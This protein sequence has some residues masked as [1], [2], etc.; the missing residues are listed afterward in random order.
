[1]LK[2]LVSLGLSKTETKVYI[3]LATKGS[4]KAR[5]IADTLN[6]SKQQLYRILK[7]LQNKEL[8]NVTHDRP[9]H[10]SVVPFDRAISLLMKAHL[11]E[12]L[13]LEQNKDEIL[14]QWHSI[15]NGGPSGDY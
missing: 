6:M 12:A 7:S 4:Q 9:S 15:I 10:F 5:T 1:V 3:Y 11:E 14:S 8:L 13:R 2:A